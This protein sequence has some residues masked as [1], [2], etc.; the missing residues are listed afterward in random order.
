M[1]SNV[2]SVSVIS[3]FWLAVGLSSFLVP[4]SANKGLTQMIIVL[5]A[6][7]CYL[8]WVLAFMH[9]LNPLI[10]PVLHNATVRYMQEAWRTS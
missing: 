8:F 5:T 9:Q 2:L 3:A 4:K 6:C 1:T 10:G 7:C